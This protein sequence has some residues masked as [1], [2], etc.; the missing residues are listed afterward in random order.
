MNYGIRVLDFKCI[1]KIKPF[2]LFTQ[3]KYIAVQATVYVNFT[4]LIYPHSTG[5][6][7]RL[8]LIFW[9]DWTTQA[10]GVGHHYYGSH[11]CF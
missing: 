10:A 9:E 8:T 7:D 6:N 5:Y 2:L 3:P 11:V 1:M 4:V